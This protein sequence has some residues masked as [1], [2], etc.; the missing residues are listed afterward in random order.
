MV[1]TGTGA[2]VRFDNGMSK[3]SGKTVGAGVEAVMVRMPMP[4]PEW[5]LILIMSGKLKAKGPF[6]QNGKVCLIVKIDRN[7]QAFREPSGQFIYPGS[8]TGQ[9]SSVASGNAVDAQADADHTV[10]GRRKGL[11]GSF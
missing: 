3:L 9:R 6:A 7:I 4:T 8:N 11:Y 5:M 2:S 1:S 10:A